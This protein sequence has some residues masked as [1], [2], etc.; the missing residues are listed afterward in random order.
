M[1]LLLHVCDRVRERLPGVLSTIN[2]CGDTL[3]VAFSYAYWWRTHRKRR[4]SELHIDRCAKPGTSTPVHVVGRRELDWETMRL[5]VDVASE[6]MASDTLASACVSHMRPLM[7]RYASGQVATLLRQ[8]AFTPHL[9]AFAEELAV[10]QG[11]CSLRF[12]SGAC[13]GFHPVH[14]APNPKQT[15]GRARMCIMVRP[16]E[17]CL[18]RC[19]QTGVSCEGFIDVPLARDRATQFEAAVID[20]YVR[21][22]VVRVPEGP[23]A[24]AES[25]LTTLRAA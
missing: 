14:V 23:A 15:S 19:G 24:R 9:T 17:A 5:M 6:H 8:L 2:L 1:S 20:A 10:A 12:V 13:I 3:V 7:R 11:S 4:Y 25:P 22:F 18:L 16:C 21:K